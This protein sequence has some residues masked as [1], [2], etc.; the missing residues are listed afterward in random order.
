MVKN[1]AYNM[2]LSLSLLVPSYCYAETAAIAID[3]LRN[4]NP[5][6]SLGQQIFYDTNL[7]SPAGQAC[8]SCHDPKTVFTDPILGLPVSNGIVPGRTGVRNTPSIVYAIFSPALYFDNDGDTYIGGQFLDGRAASLSQQAQGPFL[9]PNEMNNANADEVVEKLRTAP[10]AG[11]FKQVYGDNALENTAQAYQ[12]MADA[13]AQ[14]EMTTVFNRFTAKYDYYLAGMSTF[15]DQEK[16]GLKL[17]NDEN[18]GNCAAC[19]PSDSDT[20]TPPLFTDYSYDNIGVP[21]NPAILS[22]KGAD[23]I[24]IGLGQTVNNPAQDGKF[25]VPSLHNV[26]KTSPYMHNGVFTNLRDVVEFYSTRD[27]NP[28][29]G[30]P[31]VAATENKTELGNLRLTAAEMDAIVAFLNTLTDGYELN[32]IVNHLNNSG[33]MTLPQVRLRG[34]QSIR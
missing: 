26:A 27:T 1:I 28:N 33:L 24:D 15:T 19:H 5:V 18:K 29:W 13:I 31:E 4:L 17:F 11:L 9:N 34:N 14:F 7:S 12:Q 23:Y 32:N 8:V 21:S 3:D 20:D 25:K 2:I 16:W 10:Y 22:L 6:Q 30:K